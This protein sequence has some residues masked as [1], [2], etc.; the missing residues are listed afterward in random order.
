MTE[1]WGTLIRRKE[2]SDGEWTGLHTAETRNSEQ[3]RE[4]KCILKNCQ[5]TEPHSPTGAFD[6]STEMG[7]NEIRA[8]SSSEAEWKGVNPRPPPHLTPFKTKQ[9]A[10]KGERRE[11]VSNVKHVV[12]LLAGAEHRENPRER[13]GETRR[14]SL[15]G[16]LGPG[17]RE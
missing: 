4:N 6:L 3:P 17:S 14:R 10:T 2:Q 16:P 15:A 8:C 5:R 1:A 7:A 9:M 11:G 12:G 13:G